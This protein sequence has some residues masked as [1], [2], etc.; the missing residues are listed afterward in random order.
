MPRQYRGVDV[1]RWLDLTGAFDKTIDDE[2]DAVAARR[3]PSLQVVGRPDH[4]NLDLA[5]SS[6]NQSPR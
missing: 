1:F 2:E 3:E 6:P 4:R 5:T